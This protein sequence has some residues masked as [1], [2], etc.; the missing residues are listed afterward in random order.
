MALTK[1]ERVQL[2]LLSGREG[3]SY[4]RIADEFK[5]HHPGRSSIGFSAVAKVIRKF[6]KTGSILDKPR[7][8]G[9]SVSLETKEIVMAE[10][11]TS[12]KKS[13]CRTYMELGIPEWFQQVGAPA[14]FATRVRNWLRDNFPN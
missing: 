1:E 3:W 11:Y 12:S 8:A 13:I 5:V 7:S 9:P 6:K 10:I 14:H 4:R 2:I